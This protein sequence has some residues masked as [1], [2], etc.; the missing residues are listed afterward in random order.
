LNCIKNLSV[1][2]ILYS[3]FFCA[4]S[5]FATSVNWKFT[6][7][8]Y[9]N[10]PLTGTILKQIQLSDY[11]EIK[12][13]NPLDTNVTFYCVLEDDQ[14]YDYWSK[15]NFKTTLVPGENTITVD[16]HEFVGERG[17]QRDRRKINKNK[18]KKV[19]LVVNPDSKNPSRKSFSV[20]QF[21]SIKAPT[22]SRPQDLYA[23]K[24][25][26]S[27]YHRAIP[28]LFTI[29]D[30]KTI[31]KKDRSFGFK[32]IELW[33]KQTANI[34][35]TYLDAS[36]SVLSAKFSLVLP[37]GHYR[38]ALNWNE[39]GY[40][41]VPFWSKRKLYINKKPLVIETRDNINEYLKDYLQF[42]REPPYASTVNEFYFQK[43][44]KPIEGSFTS[45]GEVEFSFEGDASA[46]ALNTLFIWPE[47]KTSEV[48][49]FF[50]QLD[51]YNSFEFERRSRPVEKKV[52]QENAFFVGHANITD[53]MIADGRCQQNVNHPLV[54]AINGLKAFTIC[55]QSEGHEAIQIEFQD[56]LAG[57]SKI[58]K[59][60]IEVFSYEYSFKGIDL[61]HET[62]QRRVDRLRRITNNR[63]SPNGYKKRYLYF[64][65]NGDSYPPGIYQSLITFSSG[66]KKISLPVVFRIL[67]SQFT[68][69]TINI[70][71]LGLGPIPKTY[72]KNA[73]NNSL[74]D[75]LRAEAIRLLNAIGVNQF[76][77]Y[78]SVDLRYNLAN[79][80]FKLNT[81]KLDDFLGALNIDQHYL[82]NSD[83]PNDL[84]KDHWRMA[85]TEEQYWKNMQDEL[86][87]YLKKNS[88]KEFIYLYSD[89][90]TGYRNAVNEDIQKVQE[91]RKTYPY[92]KYGG[93]GNLY[94]WEIGQPLYKLWDYAFYSD[95][96]N[97][98]WIKKLNGLKQ[99]FGL[100]NLCASAMSNLGFCFGP[101]LYL[102]D[103]AGIT[104][105]LEW[106]AH[107][108]HNYP[109]FDLDGRESDI[110]LFYLNPNQE[111]DLTHRYTQAALGIETY[112]KFKL[113]EQNILA[114][115]NLTAK[116]QQAK[117]WLL[118]I[119]EHKIFPVKQYYEKYQVYFREILFELNAH[120]VSFE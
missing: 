39:L 35:P 60:A 45:D 51:A 83:F 109:G 112:Q 111:I 11:I 103:K 29:V 66:T 87:P 12:L 37:K 5:S 117:K 50:K 77:D 106:H 4:E 99:K 91:L 47:K 119:Q 71:F 64:K 68:K 34:L 93:F 98:S 24:F 67:N 56:F 43:I 100:Y 102:L 97:Q 63:L 72:F 116:Q 36:L 84:L 115:K 22:L 10:I 104:T 7:S 62:Y 81:S 26:G 95:M 120:L 28:K 69:P 89:E 105:V 41:D 30:E 88:K 82:Y 79:T 110:A 52:D 70:G 113:L 86:N 3:F 107:A 2:W 42:V 21:L 61:N 8:E 25:M 9:F 92:F 40:W 48:D 55:L 16:L 13:T 20:G 90:A 80:H 78:P 49:L 65:I 33:R 18:L 85:Q 14:S 53:S 59:E 17:S 101:Q 44:F 19:F 6:E 31:L 94:D 76:T 27:D 1:C 54:T 46:I 15:L 23:F 114:A 32:Q 38:F 118:K 75:K 73:N 57:S 96:P 108:I 58:S 74:N